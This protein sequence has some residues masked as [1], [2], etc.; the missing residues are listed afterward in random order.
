MMKKLVVLL[1]CLMVL[2]MVANADTIVLQDNLSG[3]TGFDDCT[4]MGTTATSQWYN[5]GENG[6]GQ[7]GVKGTQWPG[8]H[9][10]M[11]YD[12]SIVPELAGKTITGATLAMWGRDSGYDEQP[13]GGIDIHALLPANAGWVEGTGDPYKPGGGDVT[14]D[15]HTE[16]TQAW[17]G[18]E[19]AST[20]GTDYA[21]TPM[22]NL[23]WDQNGTTGGYLYEAIGGLKA[24]LDVATIQDWLDNPGNNAGMLLKNHLPSA[25]DP[26][27]SY[28]CAGEWGG[29][30]PINHGYEPKLTIE[31][32]PEPTT[33]VL[34]GLGGLLLRRRK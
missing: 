25:Q 1:S 14:W 26:T 34:L 29:A 8:V 18:S 24:E 27:Q 5:F 6:Q 2:S 4:L 30:D 3:Y 7:I 19:G 15:H 20:P 11:R 28:L 16:A 22:G 32:I 10:I 12:L 33:M 9:F 23:P 21:A 13:I 31:Y 17:A